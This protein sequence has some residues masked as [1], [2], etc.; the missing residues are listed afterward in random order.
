MRTL[1][2]FNFLTLDGYY[3]GLNEDISWHHHGSEEAEFASEGAQTETTL[4]FGRKT[5]EMMASYW[6]TEQGMKDNPGVADGMNKSRKIVLS[7]SLKTAT[8]QNSQIIENNA[9]E[10]IKKLKEKGDKDMT[11]LGS[12]SV[13]TQLA[14]AGLVD[15]F[16]FMIDPVALGKGTPVFKDL[17]QTLNLHL[18]DSKTFRTGVV[19]LTYKPVL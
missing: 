9:V 18:T 14:D 12:G 17:K 15:I 3:K 11:V 19:L 5:F 2:V 8:W 13:V 10:E 4:I 16:Q 1:S 6:P 7:R